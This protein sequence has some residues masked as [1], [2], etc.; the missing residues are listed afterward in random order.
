VP[1]GWG[2]DGWGESDVDELVAALQAIHA[3]RA[4]ADRRGAAAS[5]WI[6]TELSWTRQV[7]RFAGVLDAL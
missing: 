7:D 1:S 3:D 2:S 5:D 4:E 6:R